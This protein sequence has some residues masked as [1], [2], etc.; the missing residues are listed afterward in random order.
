MIL[1]K[2]RGNK[3]LNGNELF[4]QNMKK[5]LQRNKKLLEEFGLN[6][7]VDNCG[8]KIKSKTMEKIEVILLVNKEKEIKS[9]NASYFRFDCVQFINGN[10]T[11]KKFQL[12]ADEFLNGG[13]DMLH[14]KFGIMIFGDT[15]QADIAWQ[16]LRKSVYNAQH[17]VVYENIGWQMD[18]QN[19]IFVYANVKISVNGLEKAV[20]LR[21]C[22]DLQPTT[23]R[24]T[25]RFIDDVYLNVMDQFYAKVY[26]TYFCLSNLKFLLQRKGVIPSFVLYVKWESGTGKT[27]TTLPMLNPLDLNSVSI[28]DSQAAAM[29]TLNE[30]NLGVTIFDDFKNRRNSAATQLLE[31][32]IRISGDETTSNRRM[33][34]K[35]V[36]NVE[37]NNLVAVTV[38]VD[39]PVQTS[40]FARILIL[41]FDQT[42]I[43]LEQLK[44]MKSNSEQFKK[45]VISFLMNYLQW[46]M[47]NNEIENICTDIQ[48][49]TKLYINSQSNLH[50]RYINII[51]HLNSIWNSVVK[52][53]D[54]N[55]VSLD[56]KFEEDLIKMVKRQ[57]H[58]KSRQPIPK[59]Y[60]QALFELVESGKISIVDN[61]ELSGC[62]YIPDIVIKDGIWQ[63]RN[64]GAFEKIK[65]YYDEQL[66]D[67]YFSER[68]IR[69]ELMN[70]NLILKSSN[71]NTTTTSNRR[72]KG[73][74]YSYMSFCPQRA[75]EYL[76]RVDIYE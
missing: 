29:T 75:K 8:I 60:C 26:L 42:T 37:L 54:E 27:S 58:T 68:R 5:V 17:T 57:N 22:K 40:S 34:G 46:V 74:S 59:L 19:P 67:F 12:T 1:K 28:G 4:K 24:D 23:S 43:N 44:N 63:I 31:K 10:K 48:N 15:T 25:C 41:E 66:V 45:N 32:I 76:E 69:T 14:K 11:A 47:Q 55:G 38:E 65:R 7:D 53:C 70:S 9:N 49:C 33:R 18:Q 56:K 64:K 72:I 51:S 39:P 21:K 13:T 3:M 6:I 62:N 36:E 73:L 20:C 61:S 2:E 30:N 50:G 35:T 16:I 52:F 71:S